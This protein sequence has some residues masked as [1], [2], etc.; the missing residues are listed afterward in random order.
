MGGRTGG[1]RVTP[2]RAGSLPAPGTS[3]DATRVATPTFDSSAPQC[4]PHALM[5]HS[6]W[7]RWQEE[8]ESRGF[9]DIARCAAFVC[10]LIT[11]GEAS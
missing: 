6:E 8:S 3:N 4:T 9:V 7:L 10:M 5:Q 1:A 2:A 11:G